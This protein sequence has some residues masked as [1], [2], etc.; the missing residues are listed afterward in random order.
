MSGIG[1]KAEVDE[2][3]LYWVLTLV[4]VHCTSLLPSDSRRRRSP[5]QIGRLDAKATREPVDHVD[6][7]SMNAPFNCADVGT[8]NLCAIGKLLLRQAFG[9]SE[10]S[11]I[12]RQHLSYLHP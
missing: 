10:F 1:P 12:E 8:I 5:E 9:V 11:Q 7:G 3:P 2:A 4:V 6:A